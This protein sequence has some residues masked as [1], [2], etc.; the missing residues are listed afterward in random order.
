MTSFREPRV[1]WTAGDTWRSFAPSSFDPS[2]ETLTCVTENGTAHVLNWRNST[3]RRVPL[4]GQS[5]A[6]RMTGDNEPRMFRGLLVGTPCGLAIWSADGIRYPHRTTRV[7]LVLE[8]DHS[9]DWL[10]SAPGTDA[11]ARRRPELL[12]VDGHPEEHCG[13]HYCLLDPNEPAGSW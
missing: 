6:H 5:G 1:I 13:A 10:E 11:W 12:S 2:N 3:W 9:D 4:E 7:L 8:G